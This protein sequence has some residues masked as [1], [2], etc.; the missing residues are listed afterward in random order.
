V[1]FSGA[2]LFIIDVQTRNAAFDHLLE[3]LENS[4]LPALPAKWIN[5]A[6]LNG[7]LRGRPLHGDLSGR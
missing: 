4:F 7:A 2:Y 5:V 3:F 1:G 6:I